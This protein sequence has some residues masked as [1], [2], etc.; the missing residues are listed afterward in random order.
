MNITFDV[1]RAVAANAKLLGLGVL[2]DRTEKRLAMALA[3]WQEAHG[4]EPDGAYD[5][6]TEESLNTALAAF[7]DDFGEPEIVEVP[8]VAPWTTWTSPNDLVLGTPGPKGSAWWRA[9]IVNCHGTLPGVPGKWYVQLHRKVVPA[10]MEGLRRAQIAAPGYKIER[11]GGWVY[12]HMRHDPKMPLST[13]ARGKALDFDPNR[14]FA[15]TYGKGE[16][17]PEPWSPEWLRTWP[18]GLPRAFVEAMES[19]GWRWGGRWRAPKGKRGFR[20]PMHF[21]LAGTK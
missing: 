13:H 3:A 2:A 17:G 12:R 6:A 5:R 4:L 7:D 16:D 9:N 1:D 19:C 15:I 14:N 20:D 18:D 21:E 10:A 11:C 8:T